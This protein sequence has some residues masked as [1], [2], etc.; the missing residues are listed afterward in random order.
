MVVTCNKMMERN[1]TNWSLFMGSKAKWMHRRSLKALYKLPHLSVLSQPSDELEK[2]LQRNSKVQRIRSLSLVRVQRE[3]IWDTKHWFRNEVKKIIKDRNLTCET[4]EELEREVIEAVKNL[5][6][7]EQPRST[8]VDGPWQLYVKEL[9]RR[10]GR[11]YFHR[12]YSETHGGRLLSTHDLSSRE[13]GKN[14]R[15]RDHLHES[16]KSDT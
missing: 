7:R 5:I 11:K 12:M 9:Q 8:F 4:M 3:D 14:P 6:K 2:A 16:Q 15:K 13:R 1:Q 10:Q